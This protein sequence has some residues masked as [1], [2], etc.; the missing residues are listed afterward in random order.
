MPDRVED[1]IRAAAKTHGVPEALALAVA[2]QES[3]FNP[4]LVN[5]DSGAIGTFQILPAT[6][7]M[8]KIDPLDPR[9]NIDGGVK[10]LR[11]LLDQHQGDLG[12]VLGTYGGV[13]HD[14]AYVPGVL[15]RV[16]KFK[17][18]PTAA[19][20]AAGGTITAAADLSDVGTGGRPL[21]ARGTSGVLAQATQAAQKI[22]PGRS[23]AADVA[24]Q[25]GTGAKR[26]AKAVKDT[27]DPTTPSGRV[28]LAATVGSTAATLA[29][30]GGSLLATGGLTAAKGL[31]PAAG[32]ILIPAMGAAGGG[33]AADA[34]NAL[35]AGK[36]PNAKDALQTGAVQAAYELGGQAL[37]WPV[38]KVGN[39]ILAH[40][41]ARA[42]MKGLE[43]KAIDV[44]EAGIAAVQSVR[45]AGRARVALA[46]EAQAAAT[47]A[48]KATLQDRK[49]AV[50]EAGQAVVEKAKA[51]VPGPK[52]L[53]GTQ[54]LPL[55]DLELD[56]A[57]D[58]ARA[59]Q[60]LKDMQ[61]LVPSAQETAQAVR[62]TVVGRPGVYPLGDEAEGAATRALRQ[63][64]EAVAAAAAHEDAP[65]IATTKLRAEAARLASLYPPTSLTGQA[66]EQGAERAALPTAIPGSA[67]D[68]PFRRW[69]AER[70]AMQQRLQQAEAA[71]EPPQRVLPGLL[72][73]LQNAPEEISFE[74]AHI[75]KTM[76]DSV[77]NW[78]V[79]QKPILKNVTKLLRGVLRE[80]MS[81][82]QP[83]DDATRAYQAVVPLYQRG[84]TRR[85]ID[86]VGKNATPDKAERILNAKDPLSAMRVQRLLLDQTAAGGDATQGQHAWN[87]IRSAW[88]HRHVIQ[89][90]I[91]K[92]PDR[93]AK[94][95]ETPE[96]TATV[97][98]DRAGQEILSNLQAIA[99]AY[100][101][102]SARLGDLRKQAGLLGDAGVLEAS[103]V[104]DKALR[105]IGRM[106]D[107]EFATFQQQQ[108]RI[109]RGVQ[110]AVRTEAEAATQQRRFAADAMKREMQDFAGSSVGRALKTSVQLQ[111]GTD[112]LRA[113][114][115]F[116]SNWGT[117][118][119]MRLLAGAKRADLLQYA[120][121]AS[122]L[123]RSL[124]QT[125]SSPMDDRAVATTIRMF[126][127]QAYGD[128]R[129][130]PPA[131][132]PSSASSSAA[133]T[134]APRSDL[135]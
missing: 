100:T 6:G 49:L 125:L 131:P 21:R 69:I 42:A 36:P 114:L 62:A 47:L 99:Q 93:L 103:A 113:I 16:G 122:P 76:L 31:L 117:L 110:E 119:A 67:P 38:R 3:G 5:K 77:V 32:R 52:T 10:Y 13:V 64:G 120:S 43:R 29:T 121:Y 70:N 115:L 1:L 79:S 111:E 135:P 134:A 15:A 58:I 89:G 126:A 116:K 48:K 20:A 108:G 130:R 44:R 82:F 2:E 128:D 124:V 85:L 37:M 7:A 8:L 18:A 35:L 112:A 55:A 95:Q 78:D 14:T 25:I 27:Y 60:T 74:D 56:T 54:G 87:L 81:G 86:A 88:T 80:E 33:A 94:L 127:Q 59:T 71:G 4:T 97:F 57:E 102:A 90:D 63:T 96:F 106:N 50:K 105:A 40:P 41:V 133:S 118:A 17:T 68:S 129:P 84:A 109:L 65:N 61:A 51:R 53:P 107:A 132:S 12:K 23:A 24:L 83:Y 66:A 26:I 39:A 98:G 73:L 104:M 30:G 123:T 34:G 46:E 11:Q 72:G 28:N 75:V 92:L 91:A 45:R 22:G 19:P 9:Q 101:Q